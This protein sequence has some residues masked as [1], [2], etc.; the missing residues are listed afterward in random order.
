MPR[1]ATSE[2]ACVLLQT[3]HGAAERPNPQDTLPC[4]GRRCPTER[5]TVRPR[6]PEPNTTPHLATPRRWPGRAPS[7]HKGDRP[8]ARKQAPNNTTRHKSDLQEDLYEARAMPCQ[9]HRPV[10]MKHTRSGVFRFQHCVAIRDGNAPTEF[11][12]PAE[13]W[14]PCEPR[15]TNDP[16]TGARS[17][18]RPC[19]LAASAHCD[20][21]EFN[22]LASAGAGPPCAT[23]RLN[24]ALKQAPR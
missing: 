21:A 15:C 22:T 6:P 4:I 24:K 2:C 7:R 3:R 14:E 10:C 13:R 1:N 5:P 19:A 17:R 16:H 9:K 8:R 23:P 18:P 11:H 12:A 20:W